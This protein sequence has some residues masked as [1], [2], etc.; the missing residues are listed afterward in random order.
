MDFDQGTQR[1]SSR[2]LQLRPAQAPVNSVANEN[3][4]GDHST[5][6]RRVGYRRIEHA[7]ASNAA[8]RYACLQNQQE[9][10][11]HGDE[12]EQEEDG[13]GEENGVGGSYSECASRGS[14]H[15]AIFLEQK[16]GQTLNQTTD[17]PADKVKRYK[18][19]AAKRFLDAA[20]KPEK[21]QTIAEQMPDAGVKELK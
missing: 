11:G 3:D 6:V 19:F 17:D 9:F 18:T 4:A 1:T 5:Q 8:D 15:I 20:A 10:G 21:S 16:H 13:I 14:K 7:Q 12:K 2:P